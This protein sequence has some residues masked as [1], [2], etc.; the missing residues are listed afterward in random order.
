MGKFRQVNFE[1]INRSISGPWVVEFSDRWGGPGTTTFEIL[2]DWS[3][4]QDKRI[5]YYSGTAAYQTRF[6]FPAS[7]MEGSR[8]RY[9]LDLGKVAVIAEVVLNGKTL[10][11]LLEKRHS[12]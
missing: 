6:D 11:T 1:A 4:H 7:L 3:E 10:G 8:N 9:Y 12:G 5:R 2:K